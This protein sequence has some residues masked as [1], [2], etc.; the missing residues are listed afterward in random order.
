M[1]CKTKGK[2]AA[3]KKKA[4][5]KAPAKRK[6]IQSTEFSLIAPEAQEVFLA[7]D[8]NDWNTTEY[9][10]RK[11][12]NGKCVKK[13]K[14]KPGK[15]EYQFVV[16]GHWWVDPENPNRQA[17]NFGSENSVIEVGEDVVVVK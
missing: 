5:A 2:C 12:K 15:Y 11:F 4:K 8:F 7:G 10:M 9:P 6:T 13:L 3:P 17:N 1:A 16:D 14:L